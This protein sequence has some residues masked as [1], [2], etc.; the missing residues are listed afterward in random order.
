MSTMNNYE[1]ITGTIN[2]NAD[3]QGCCRII[4]WAEELP[5]SLKDVFKDNSQN[6]DSSQK[7]KFEHLLVNF[8][9]IF[10]DDDVSGKCNKIC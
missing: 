7:Q 10:E 5:D 6:L 1:L 2:S 3:E 9:N 4:E 8:Q